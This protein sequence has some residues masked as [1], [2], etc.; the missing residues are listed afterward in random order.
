[1][2]LR[3]CTKR[4]WASTAFSISECQRLSSVNEAFTSCCSDCSW[5][6]ISSSSASSFSFPPLWISRATSCNSVS[7][8]SPFCARP[9]RTM[10]D[11][12]LPGNEFSV[13]DVPNTMNIEIGV[14]S[15]TSGVY[16]ISLIIRHCW[17]GI[18]IAVIC[19][20]TPVTSTQ[21]TN[22][23]STR[24]FQ[25]VLFFPGEIAVMTCFTVDI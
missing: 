9:Y 25:P 11:E 14:L 24:Y 17:C 23:W 3:W 2:H 18:T 8:R 6:T 15:K 10:C 1:M 5:G 19:K 21:T 4:E 13:R 7:L 16:N 20:P 12:Y 22:L